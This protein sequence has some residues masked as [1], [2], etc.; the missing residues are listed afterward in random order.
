MT[1]QLDTLL[2]AVEDALEEV[3]VPLWQPDLTDP[4]LPGSRTVQEAA[5]Q[6]DGE[7]ETRSDQ[8]QALSGFSALDG[9]QALPR[10]QRAGDE[11]AERSGQSSGYTQASHQEITAQSPSP[12]LLMQLQQLEAAQASVEALGRSPVS[13][14]LSARSSVEQ[15]GSGVQYDPAALGDFPLAAAAAAAQQEDRARAVDRAFQRDSRRYDRGF[16]LY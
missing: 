7:A 12:A 1:N 9:W 4:V 16:S 5:G 8:S 11:N 2:E 14:S 15:S 10:F 6:E 3:E 13:S